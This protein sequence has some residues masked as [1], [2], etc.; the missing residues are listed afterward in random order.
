MVH[1]LKETHSD[2]E[3]NET[4]EPLEQREC[5]Q[6]FVAASLVLFISFHLAISSSR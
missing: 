5:E 6:T 1:Q 2:Q 4:F 3:Q